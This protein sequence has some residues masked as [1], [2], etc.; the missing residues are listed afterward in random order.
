MTGAEIPGG[1][2]RGVVSGSKVHFSGMSLEDNGTVAMIIESVGDM[3][4]AETSSGQVTVGGSEDCQVTF[5]LSMA[6]D[7][8]GTAGGD[9]PGGGT[10]DDTTGSSSTSG[11]GGGGGGCM[12][13]S[14]TD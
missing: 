12:I 4:S 6:L 8:T 9:D 1:L 2:L 7:T 10:S 5:D 11:G 3:T 14:I 13:S